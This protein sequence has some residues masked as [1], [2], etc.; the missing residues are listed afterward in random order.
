MTVIQ[1]ADH[2]TG[3]VD[4]VSQLVQKWLK[5]DDVLQP[6]FLKVVILVTRDRKSFDIGSIKRKLQS[7]FGTI[8][9][10]TVLA[11]NLSPAI[12]SGPFVL[13]KGEL[14]KAARL[15]DDSQQAFI[16]ATKPQ[17][18]PGLVF[19]TLLYCRITFHSATVKLSNF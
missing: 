14:L 19:K 17:T 1:T 6:D 12:T 4:W 8:W 15:Y 7:C 13:W 9:S 11:H 16:V 2:E 18:V 5:F 10:A 3:N